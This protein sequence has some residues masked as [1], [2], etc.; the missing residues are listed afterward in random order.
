[1]KQKT[2]SFL[3]LHTYVLVVASGVGVDIIYPPS[4]CN[5]DVQ[6]ADS[7]RLGPLSEVCR[8]NVKRTFKICPE[9]GR[10]HFD[11]RE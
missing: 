10:I 4:S 11:E 7:A 6:L 9:R 2:K 1:M 8:L 5:K 3:P